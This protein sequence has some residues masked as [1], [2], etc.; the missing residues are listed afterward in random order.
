MRAQLL[1]FFAGDI[2]LLESLF[3][4][5]LG[6]WKQV[7]RLDSEVAVRRSGREEPSV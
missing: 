4:L 1:P 3:D 2:E 5:D 7:P 6:A